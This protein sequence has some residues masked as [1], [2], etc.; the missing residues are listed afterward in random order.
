MGEKKGYWKSKEV[1]L[2]LTL[3]KTFFGIVYGPVIREKVV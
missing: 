1:A 3:R 2:D